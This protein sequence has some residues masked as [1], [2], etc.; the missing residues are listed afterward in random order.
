MSELSQTLQIAR[1][2]ILIAG[3]NREVSDLLHR[4]LTLHNI[5]HECHIRTQKRC[6]LQ[7]P[8]LDEPVTQSKFVI[9][10][11][12]TRSAHDAFTATTPV[13]VPIN[14]WFPNRV[15]VAKREVVGT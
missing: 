11:G 5:G 7:A 3:D 12:Q 4:H 6:L 8:L 13:K 15:G 9:I 2:R 1:Y 14:T 10:A